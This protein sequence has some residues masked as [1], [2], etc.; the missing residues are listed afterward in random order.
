LIQGSVVQK[1]CE[2]LNTL[3]FGAQFYEPVDAGETYLPSTEFTVTR[4]NRAAV[5][6]YLNTSSEY[7]SP[8]IDLD[9]MALLC[10][11]NQVNTLTTDEDTLDKGAALS[12]YITREAELND[13]ADQLNIYLDVNRPT[14]GSN[15]LLYAKLKY[16]SATYSDWLLVDPQV[17]IP[18]TDDRN[19]FNEV[20]YVLSSASND[21]ISL[22]IKLVFVSTSTVDVACAKNLRII[23]TS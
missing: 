8:V 11:H 21:F 17:K 16:D 18:I 13:P 3:T 10:V 4:A 23:A 1:E 12:R 7:V 6:S 5:N 15:I 9:N 14:E 22:A 20:S 2:L 19:E